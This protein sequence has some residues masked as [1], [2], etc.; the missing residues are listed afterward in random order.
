MKVQKLAFIK[1]IPE[2]FYRCKIDIEAMR[3]LNADTKH[4]TKSLLLSHVVYSSSFFV[5][6]L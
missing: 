4:A 6:V 3:K 1:I 5:S 2:I